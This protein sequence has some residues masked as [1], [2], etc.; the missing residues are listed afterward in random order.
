MAI[1]LQLPET[2]DWSAFSTPYSAYP[3]MVYSLQ[4]SLASSQHR[5]VAL[6]IMTDLGNPYQQSDGPGVLSSGIVGVR[7]G[8]GCV[9]GVGLTLMG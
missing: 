2:G 4:P 9:Q 7:C 6:I 5:C 3:S 8:V 1:K